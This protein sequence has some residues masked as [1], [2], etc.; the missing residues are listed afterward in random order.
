MNLAIIIL[1]FAIRV[2]TVC[3]G[4]LALRIVGLILRKIIQHVQH[5]RIM[6]PRNMYFTA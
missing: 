2:F 5:E 1:W 4:L 3:I 6:R